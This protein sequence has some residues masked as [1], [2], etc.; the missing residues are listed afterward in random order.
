MFT[1]RNL[2]F[3]SIIGFAINLFSTCFLQAGLGD[4][5][6]PGASLS[7]SDTHLVGEKDGDESG[8]SVANAGDVD[9]DGL[10]DVLVG[11]PHSDNRFEFNSGKTYL[12]LAKSILSHSGTID[13]GNADY[14]FIGENPGDGSGWSV[15]S[16]GDLDHDGRD[17]ILI[18]APWFDMPHVVGGEGIWGIL[19]ARTNVG[20]TYVI[21]SSTILASS[22]TV[23]LSNADYSI[24]GEDYPSTIGA[25]V[26]NAGDVDGDGYNDILIGSW[27]GST[28][29]GGPENGVA[30]LIPGRTLL[31]SS[32]TLDL[33]LNPP[34]VY[35][36]YLNGS[37]NH[38]GR[39]VSSA[40][41]VD[42]DG[43]ADILIGGPRGDP[44]PQIDRGPGKVYLKLGK[45]LPMP[46][47]L[48]SINLSVQADY[49]FVG[50][51]GS[52][53][54]GVGSAVSNAGDIDGDGVPDLL[55]GA[56]YDDSGGNNAG[57]VYLVLGSTIGLLPVGSTIN[58]SSADYFFP[59]TDPD[60]FL[61][62]SVSS[63]GDI[64]GDGLADILMGAPE[65]A[66][67][68]T[69][70]DRGVTYLFKGSKIVASGG[71]Q[72][73]LSSANYIFK[74]EY[75]RNASGFSVSGAGDVNG[76]HLSDILIGAPKNDTCGVDAGKTY[77]V[78]TGRYLD[79]QHNE[80]SSD[81]KSEKKK[82]PFGGLF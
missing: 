34:N 16:A 41:D 66:Y 58:L 65:N 44:W 68:S 28:Q 43:L 47:S 73:Q 6:N 59:G 20:K 80:G 33:L 35:R 49:T 45:N 57:K 77:L 1:L 71:G 56:P 63:A 21:L 40:G 30:Y 78:L 48:T 8:R 42:G 29:W 32:G 22:G 17:D 79:S 26:A 23:N 82:S 54:D 9:G 46:S 67:S 60:D 50:D 25:S 81:T 51:G 74:G 12:I 69:G 5:V 61:G 38:L 75:L 10:N 3:Y 27:W 19:V 64:D 14:V 52:I 55:M 76:D 62:R 36:F 72:I 11:S 24:I 31:A 70:P 39:S 7:L 4:F 53:E 2:C 13:L 15:A 37:Y 18:G